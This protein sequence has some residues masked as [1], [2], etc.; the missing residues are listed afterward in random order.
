MS[1]PVW[2]LLRINRKSGSRVWGGAAQCDLQQSGD[3][4]GVRGVKGQTIHLHGQVTSFPASYPKTH[5]SGKDGLLLE[6]EESVI[7]CVN[8]RPR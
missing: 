3:D 2:T 8:G 6:E 5:Q 1:P 4:V 7:V